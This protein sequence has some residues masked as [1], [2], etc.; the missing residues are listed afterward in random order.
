MYSPAPRANLFDASALVRVF[1]PEPG[2]D[3]VRDYFNL[4]SPTKYTTPFCFYETL[5]ILKGKWL[6]RGELTKAQYNEAAFRFVA[7]FE[8]C[9]RHGNDIDLK[10]PI[11]FSKVR[12]LS[13]R[14]NLDWSDAFQILSVREGYFSCLIDESQTVLVTADETLATVACAEGV[15]AWYCLKAPLP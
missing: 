15:K 14:H 7:W 2:S 1:A 6:F 13:E 11:V 5:N 10:D 4:H 9:T 8:S 12:D 3:L